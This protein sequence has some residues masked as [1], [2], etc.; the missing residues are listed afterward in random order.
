MLRSAVD[1]NDNKV[2]DLLKRNKRL[3]FA[4]DPQ[5]RTALHLAALNGNINV[6]RTILASD[7]EYTKIQDGV[8]SH[9]CQ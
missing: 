3:V 2:K 1:G 8:G 7:A 6:I 4:R 9:Q 5:G